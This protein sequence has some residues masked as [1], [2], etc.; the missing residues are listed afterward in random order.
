[1]ST[2]IQTDPGHGCL[3][4]AEFLERMSFDVS[5][6]FPMA[7]CDS[8]QRGGKQKSHTEFIKRT[9]SQAVT[10]SVCKISGE[11]LGGMT[12]HGVVRES[13]LT[14]LALLSQERSEAHPFLVPPTQPHFLCM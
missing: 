3:L 10:Q 9:C 5:V 13:R 11:E 2:Q 12:N 1:M 4:R 7:H 8:N 6:A 14:V